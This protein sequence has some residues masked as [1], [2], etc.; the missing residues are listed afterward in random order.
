MSIICDASAVIVGALA[1]L[2]MTVG[3]ALL[4]VL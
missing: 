3:Y 2:A 4:L 1:A